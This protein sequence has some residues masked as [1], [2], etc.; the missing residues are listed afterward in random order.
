MAEE[1]KAVTEE[2]AEERELLTAPIGKTFN[3]YSVI[4]MRGMIA[5]VIMVVIE[6]VIMG[7]G[8]GA[9]GLACVGIIMSVEYINLA[10]GNLY[11]TGVPTVVGNYLGAG[12]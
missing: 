12:D 11:G 2:A 9:H 8:L 1:E 6:G 4:T 3:K 10:F 5:Q 7:A